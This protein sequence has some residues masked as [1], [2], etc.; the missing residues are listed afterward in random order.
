MNLFQ[1][2][3]IGNFE[4]ASLIMR[5]AKFLRIIQSATEEPPELIAGLNGNKVDTEKALI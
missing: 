4:E 5:D 1:A 2:I 3:L